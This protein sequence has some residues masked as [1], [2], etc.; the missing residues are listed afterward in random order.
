MI[1]ITAPASSAN[2]GPG[3]DC[4]GIAL[5]MYDS[6]RV[7]ASREYSVSGTEEKYSGPDNLFL[8]S[9]R[10][11]CSSLGIGSP[12]KIAVTFDC[13][14]PSSRG[15]GSSAALSASG[16]AAAF[17]VNGIPLSQEEVFRIASD[18][19]GHPDNAAPAVYG[20]LR[21]SLRC[22]DS[23]RSEALDVSPALRFT[24]LI[25]DYEVSTGEARRILPSSYPRE[26]AVSGIS[27]AVL[28]CRALARGDMGLM[29]EA[30]PDLIH[31]PYR[32]RL[33]PGYE[34]LKGIVSGTGD[35]VLVISGSGST[36]LAVSLEPLPD[37]ARQSILSLR[38]P[39]WR[40]EELKVS[41]GIRIK[42]C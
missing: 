32:S 35:A 6:F 31:E 34:R 15:L 36:C 26:A 23:W 17:A 3:F 24:A 39:S 7:E 42:R 21:A 8:V 16:A 4:L 22:R 2:L 29:K 1:E 20:G 5:S 38:D 33:I 14:I 25:P 11:A 30:A 27:H 9:Y 19:E 10:R 28:M 12:R 37:T 40:I 41:G 18:I 13:G